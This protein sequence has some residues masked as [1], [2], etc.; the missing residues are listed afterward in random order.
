MIT[1]VNTKGTSTSTPHSLFTI[2]DTEEEETEV[3][4]L[5]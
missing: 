2:K 4:L 3:L 5:L 1:R